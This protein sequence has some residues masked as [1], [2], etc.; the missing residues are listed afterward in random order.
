[1]ATVLNN[2]PGLMLGDGFSILAAAKPKD[3]RCSNQDGA[4][5][6]AD[7]GCYNSDAACSG[8]KDGA[9]TTTDAG[10]VPSK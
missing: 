7:D 5:T 1:M 8:P 4:C 10:C 9:C 6:G 2:I 3:E